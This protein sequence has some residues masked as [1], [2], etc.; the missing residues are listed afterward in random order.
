MTLFHVMSSTI[1]DARVDTLLPI[2]HYLRMPSLK[3]CALVEFH[4]MFSRIV[5]H[6]NM[7]KI[8]QYVQVKH[9]NLN[10]QPFKDLASFD[11]LE[12][13]NVCFIMCAFMII[14][15][16]ISIQPS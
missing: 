10:E 3:S 2:N 11:N 9:Q 13:S 4:M 8:N 16:K 6:L 5:L 12:F 7:Q 1:I 15:S 14:V